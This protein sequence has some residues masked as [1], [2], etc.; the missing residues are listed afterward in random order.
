M[1]RPV[2]YAWDKTIPNG[3]CLNSNTV[4]VSLA[5]CNIVTD[6][7]VLVLPMRWLA[8]LQLDLSKRLAVIA[9]FILGGL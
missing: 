7:V 6:L 5:A 3:R 4:Y 8:G 1:C 9:T 2:K